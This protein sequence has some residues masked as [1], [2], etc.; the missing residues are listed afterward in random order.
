MRRMPALDGLRALAI[1]GVIGYHLQL[2][3]I[4]G[5]CLGVDLFF[6]LSGFLITTLLIEQRGPLRDF[7][8]RRVRRLLPALFVLVLGTLALSTLVLP[9]HGIGEHRLTGDAFAAVFYYAN[10]HVIYLDQQ[11]SPL[12]HTWSLSIEEQ[13][14]VVWPLALLLLLRLRGWR[15]AGLVCCGLGAVLSMTE[16]ALLY[17]PGHVGQLRAYCGTD[18][19]GFALLVGC[20]L[21]FLTVGREPV[22]RVRK[23][24]HAVGPVALVGLLCF[25]VV[26]GAG[27]D[28]PAGWMYLGGFQVCAVLA[29]AVL[30]DAQ[31]ADQGALGR[32]FS[33]R[34]LVWLGQVSYGVYLWHAAV[35]FYL[36]RIKGARAGV[37]FDLSVIVATLAL[38]SASF[39][40]V[41]RPI[42]RYGR[43]ITA[44]PG[45]LRSDAPLAASPGST[46]NG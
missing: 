25:W 21:A 45:S 4:S 28:L 12:Q 14:Y 46:G 23:T 31:L 30:G 22:P 33:L 29:A 32:V 8:V 44:G 1:C 39:Y 13:F 5:G 38:A 24:L 15:T 36:A 17:Q 26:G 35:I 3:W 7:W 40:L 20:F 37:E 27:P 18:S 9:H 42:R 34:P 16:M 41:E 11:P 6:V 2:G 43:R 19:H 10:W